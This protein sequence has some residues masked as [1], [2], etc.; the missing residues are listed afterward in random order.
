MTV[1]NIPQRHLQLFRVFP[2]ITANWHNNVSIQRRELFQKERFHKH[3][4]KTVSAMA[5]RN[6]DRQRRDA[7]RGCVD[8]T[9]VDVDQC[10]RADINV[11]GNFLG[12]RCRLKGQV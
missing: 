10:G 1:P 4:D 12:H 5:I 6:R 8:L 7:G 11:R 2:R 3:R 9:A